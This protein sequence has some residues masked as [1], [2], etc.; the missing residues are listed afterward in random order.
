MIYTKVKLDNV[1]KLQ[2]LPS[3]IKKLSCHDYVRL[4]GLN[5]RP[6]GPL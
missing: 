6:V 2:F 3:A 4:R 1:S 5:R